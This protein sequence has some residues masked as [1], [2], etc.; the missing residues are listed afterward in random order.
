M[1]ACV[2]NPIQTE[3]AG[4]DPARLKAES[5]D[6]LVFWGGGVETQRVLPSG[7]RDEIRAQVKERIQTLG[8]GGGF[9]FATTHNIQEDVSADNL[10][11]MCEAVREFGQYPL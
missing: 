1:A 9:V 7:S 5:G 8:P 6:R 3:A 4:M 2:F 10:L 11:A